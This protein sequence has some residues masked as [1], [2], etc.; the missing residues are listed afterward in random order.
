M[1]AGLDS[2][3]QWAA[4]LDAVRTAQTCVQQWM[5][6]GKLTTA[7]G[8]EIGADLQAQ[9]GVYSQAASIDTAFPKVPGFLPWQTNETPGSRGYR[10]GRYVNELLFDLRTRGKISL[11]QFHALKADSDE[12]LMA[13]RRRLQ[14]DGISEASLIAQCSPPGQS[15]ARRVVPPVA[16]EVV[17]APQPSAA[18]AVPAGRQSPPTLE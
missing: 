8:E 3:Q 5:D 15:A 7:Q 9:Y 12:R 4:L 13:V 16:A 18:P 2:E 6:R 17:T 1:M 14:Q 10:A 11:T